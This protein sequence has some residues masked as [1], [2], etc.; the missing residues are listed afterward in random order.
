MDFFYAGWWFGCHF[1][2]SHILGISSSQLTFIFFRGVAQPATNMDSG[3]KYQ[4]LPYLCWQDQDHRPH[5]PCRNAYFSRQLQPST[6]VAVLG[7]PDGI[8][9]SSLDGFFHGKSQ[10]EMEKNMD[11]TS[12]KHRTECWICQPRIIWD[13]FLGV[14]IVIGLPPARWMVYK[15]KS[16]SNGWWLGVPL[17]QE[18]SMW[19]QWTI[20]TFDVPT[21]QN[22]CW[23]F[24]QRDWRD[25]L[26]NIDA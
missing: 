19:W 17:F 13:L 8:S 1:L 2:F 24:Q 20:S 25:D 12:A 14:S 7:K 22:F 15:G 3:W 23:V 9:P 10:L 6:S 18:T 4:L 21:Q 5:G 11:D 16:H 26:M